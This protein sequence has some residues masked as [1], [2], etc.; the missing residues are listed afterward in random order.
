[1]LQPTQEPLPSQNIAPPAPQA[2]LIAAL[3][4][5]QTPP[6]H[7]RDWHMV[8]VPGHSDAVLHP[9]QVPCPSQNM[10]PPV[11]QAV[12]IAAMPI[13]HTPAVHR[14]NSHVVSWPGHCEAL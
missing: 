7:V 6:M 10:L 1:V 11:P 4:M 2:V 14:R 8:S 12:S 5:P 13:P 9:T 3:L